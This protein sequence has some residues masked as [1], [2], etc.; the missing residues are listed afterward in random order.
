MT[1]YTNK[2][3]HLD[4]I[5]QRKLDE[6]VLSAVTYIERKKDKSMRPYVKTIAS[7]IMGAKTSPFY[8][9]FQRHKDVCGA[10]KR[11]SEEVVLDSLLRLER[12]KKLNKELSNSGKYAFSLVNKKQKTNKT[13]SSKTTRSKIT[14]FE[15]NGYFLIFNPYT[16]ETKHVGK[17]QSFNKREKI[18]VDA[19]T[20]R[21]YDAEV[22]KPISKEEYHTISKQ[23][24]NELPNKTKG[25]RNV[26]NSTKQKEESGEVVF[27][28]ESCKDSEKKILRQF[29]KVVENLLPDHELQNN[30][31]TY[32]FAPIEFDGEFPKKRCWITR[33][34]DSRKLVLKFKK[35]PDSSEKQLP[36][37]SDRQVTEALR[38]LRVAYST[39][40]QDID[41]VVNRIK[42]KDSFNDY[43]TNNLKDIVL[44][45]HQ[46]AGVELSDEYNR[47]AYFYDT[48]TGKTIMALEIMARKHSLNRARFLVVAPKALIKSAWMEDS[49]HFKNI[50]LLPLS[51]NITKEDYARIYDEWEIMDGRSRLL[52]DEEGNLLD[53]ISLKFIN[54]D[55]LPEL[56]RRADHFIIN[57]DSIRQPK[58]GNKLLK[59]I[60][61]DGLIIDESVIIKNRDSG[62]AIRMRVF[63][64]KMKY[65]YLLS[66]KPAPNSTI[67][68]F[69]QMELVDHETFNMTYGAFVSKYYKTVGYN[70]LV[71]KNDSTKK[72]V[73]KMVANRSI[74]VAKEDC[75]ELPPAMHKKIGVE[76]DDDTKRFYKNVMENFVA[77]IIDMEGKKI[78]VNQL[79]KFSSIMKLREIASGFYLNKNNSYCINK[80]KVEAIKDLVHEIGY[81]QFGNRNKVLIWCTFKYEIETLEKELREDGYKVVTA[82][83]D[84][85]RYLDDNISEFKN[86]D[87]DIMIAHPQTLRYGVTFI[88]CHYCIYSSMS[89]SLND[90]KQSHDRIYRNGQKELCIFYHMLSEDTIDENI[91][92]VVIDKANKSKIFEA[93]V[94]SASKHGISREDIYK[95]LSVN[96][97]I[98][99][100]VTNKKELE[101]YASV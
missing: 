66:G 95:A 24:K 46:K 9:F 23:L 49:R 73:A 14:K 67:E 2:H 87:A 83:S 37:N 38:Q 33:D 61:C 7:F 88:K 41:E 11:I 90:Y 3:Y 84:T 64:K 5:S 47:F 16:S 19:S 85:G 99:N 39:S 35:T 80:H 15:K 89:Y 86:G 70:R 93:L 40:A 72:E 28:Y 1:R 44:M 26:K 77:E 6:I 101:D 78:R 69:S 68:Y 74:I 58:E 29:K 25:K 21:K 43:H 51:K 97:E 31:S 10:V 60:K 27:F 30:R 63:A 91:Y 92:K 34:K 62:N 54:E 57:I 98:K 8:P 55:L 48:G 71:D 4:M 56:K 53:K 32:G 45:P 36:L 59:E 22:A 13:N 100:I 82:Y 65:V 96:A 79:S 94:K 20:G 12:Q 75:I 52:T 50:K 76:L 81:D 18:I 42:N 17:I